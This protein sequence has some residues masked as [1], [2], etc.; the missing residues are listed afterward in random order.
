[1]GRTDFYKDGTT[2]NTSE[3][4]LPEAQYRYLEDDD[5]KALTLKGISYAKNELYAK[6]G[7]KFESQELS[8]YMA[9]KSWY[10]PKY[11]PRTYD[12]EIVNRMNEYERKNIAILNAKEDALGPY[13]YDKN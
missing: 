5:L 3:Y 2:V 11:E 10:S 7:R 1:M 9:T 8:D 6:Y 4:I 13:E 12:G